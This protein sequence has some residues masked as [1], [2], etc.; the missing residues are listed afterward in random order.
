MILLLSLS[1]PS[2]V[3]GI[4]RFVTP[5]APTAFHLGYWQA[6]GIGAAGAPRYS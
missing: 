5:V 1:F 2:Q 4:D 3:I 6:A